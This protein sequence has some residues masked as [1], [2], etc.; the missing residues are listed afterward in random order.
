MKL[1]L[2]YLWEYP[3][4]P[5][6]N[7]GFVMNTKKDTIENLGWEE[8]VRY[9]REILDNY[10]FS[11]HPQIIRWRINEALRKREQFERSKVW[12]MEREKQKRTLSWVAVIT[13]VDIC[14][15]NVWEQFLQSLS[16]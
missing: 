6:D 11:Q 7:E 14:A 3:W 10:D 12:K 5:E 9:G 4:L 2:E 1:A 13:W 15:H 16:N 8:V